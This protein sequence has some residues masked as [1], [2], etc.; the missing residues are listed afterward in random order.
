M[1]QIN[2]GIFAGGGMDELKKKA[3]ME[4]AQVS[5]DLEIKPFFTAFLASFSRPVCRPDSV[6]SKFI[7]LNTKFIILNTKFIIF[8]AT[9]LLRSFGAELLGEDC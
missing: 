6:L 8:D 7:I 2:T 1:N 5:F 9:F 4:E 3:Q